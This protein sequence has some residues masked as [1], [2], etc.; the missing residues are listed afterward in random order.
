MNGIRYASGMRMFVPFGLVVA[1]GA[2]HGAA[3]STEA[4]TARHESA[5]SPGISVGSRVPAFARDRIDGKGR[6]ELPN[7]KVT[8]VAFWAMSWGGQLALPR[9]EKLYRDYA[10]RGLELV[11]VSHDDA[12]YGESLPE[13]LGKFGVTFP[14]VWDEDKTLIDRFRPANIMAAYVIDRE[15][16][17]RFVE[18]AG[19]ESW[20]AASDAVEAKV[21]ELLGG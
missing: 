1:L 7:G 14:V 20:P 5:A 15:G 16:V 9:Y 12:P 8:I 6:V 17:V 3:P 13:A 10:S 18:T 2:C 19:K 4:K 21:R 11:V